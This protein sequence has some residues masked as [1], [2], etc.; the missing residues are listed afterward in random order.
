MY[1][2][3]NDLVDEF[4]RYYPHKKIIIHST[5]GLNR[6]AFALAEY[7]HHKEQADRFE[8]LKDYA[9]NRQPGWLRLGTLMSYM[10]NLGPLRIEH[11]DFFMNMLEEWCDS[12]LRPNFD[13][14]GISGKKKKCL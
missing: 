14:F 13:I 6:C 3:F 7:F 4:L 1:R 11:H 8:S 9:Q 12:K 2:K 5:L 10:K